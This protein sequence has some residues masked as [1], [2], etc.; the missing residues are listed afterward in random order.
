MIYNIKTLAGIVEFTRRWEDLREP[1]FRWTRNNSGDSRWQDGVFAAHMKSNY[2]DC[3]TPITARLYDLDGNNKETVIRFVN[4]FLM[5][6]N[7]NILID[8]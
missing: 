8:V 3:D 1:F 4:E 2:I 6:G 7:A 5:D